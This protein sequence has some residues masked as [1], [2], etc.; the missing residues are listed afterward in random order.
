MSSGHFGLVRNTGARPRTKIHA[1]CFFPFSKSTCKE[2][3]WIGVEAQAPGTGAVSAVNWAREVRQAGSTIKTR[4]KGT[5]SQIVCT[6]LTS[7]N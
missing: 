5:G 7:T 1:S 6:V 2:P 4:G 3:G